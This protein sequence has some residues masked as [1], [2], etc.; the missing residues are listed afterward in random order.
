MKKNAL[1]ILL[2][3]SCT[4]VY[5]STMD[6]I[7]GVSAVSSVVTG[8]V[9]TKTVTDSSKK[10]NDALV[11]N[12]DAQTENI[13]K[14][15]GLKVVRQPDGTAKV[16]QNGVEVTTTAD[17]NSPE[18]KMGLKMAE[19]MSNYFERKD[20]QAKLKEIKAVAKIEN[21]T[22]T[23]EIIKK[24]KKAGAVVTLKK[25]EEQKASQ[26]KEEK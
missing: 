15:E 9:M 20:A 23:L 14:V 5:A 25:L 2:L 19:S 24:Y 3:L 26:V 7:T 6:V 16:Y 12:I 22:E 17:P 21:D 4:C 10:V 11:R 8:A 1:T 18:Y 13:K